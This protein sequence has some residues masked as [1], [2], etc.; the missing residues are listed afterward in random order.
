M[1][2]VTKRRYFM[3]FAEK[4]S[5]SDVQEKLRYVGVDYDIELTCTTET[6]KEK[7]YVLP[8]RKHHF[9]RRCLF[10]LRGSVSPAKFHCYR[11]QPNPRP[12]F[13][14]HHEAKF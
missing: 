5:V 9:Y 12:V 1:T 6:D 7:T 11:S 13:P 14:G 4:R 8:D 10:L 2:N 3:A